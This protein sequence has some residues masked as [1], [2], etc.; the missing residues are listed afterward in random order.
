MYNSSSSLTINVGSESNFNDKIN[1]MTLPLNNKLSSDE[2]CYTNEISIIK[3][4]V[5]DKKENMSEISKSNIENNNEDNNNNNNNNNNKNNNN[6]NENNNNNNENNNENDISEKDNKLNLKDNEKD[7]QLNNHKQR[8]ANNTN[9]IQNNEIKPIKVENN[10]ENIEIEKVNKEKVTIKQENKINE[11]IIDNNTSDFNDDTNRI[12]TILYNN[13]EKNDNYND[14]LFKLIREKEHLEYRFK[15]EISQFQNQLE[16]ANNA[17]KNFQDI[18]TNLDEELGNEKRKY[19]NDITAIHVELKNYQLEIEYLKEKLD[20]EEKENNFLIDEKNVLI[21]N[22][23]DEKD[24]FNDLKLTIEMIKSERDLLADELSKIIPQFEKLKEVEENFHQKQKE[25]EN[26]KMESEE[27]LNNGLS[28]SIEYMNLLKDFKKQLEIKANLINEA[29]PTGKIEVITESI[30]ELDENYAIQLRDMTDK[31]NI[32]VDECNMLKQELDTKDQTIT[33]K[34]KSI[35]EEVEKNKQYENTIDFLNNKILY[36]S[37][38]LETDDK[39]DKSLSFNKA[40][41]CAAKYIEYLENA[42][43]ENRKFSNDII[44]NYGFFDKVKH[45]ENLK[46][47]NISS[48][49]E[50]HEISNSKTDES[51]VSQLQK[52]ISDKDLEIESLNQKLNALLR[53]KE[54]FANTDYSTTNN[55]NIITDTNET[56]S[57]QI[58]GSSNND[59]SNNEELE[60]LRRQNQKLKEA[61]DAK[62]NLIMEFS[63]IEK[64]NTDES[65]AMYESSQNTQEGSSNNSKSKIDHSSKNSNISNKKSETS[66]S[67]VIINNGSDK[68]FSLDK[69]DFYKIKEIII[70]ILNDNKEREDQIKNLNEKMEIFI[71][72][73]NENPYSIEDISKF[74][75]EYISAVNNIYE[76]TKIHNFQFESFISSS[77][78]LVDK[79]TEFSKAASIKSLTNES[80]TS[81]NKKSI[82]VDAKIQTALD[83]ILRID[84]FTQTNND[85]I[86]KIDSYTQIDNDND[87]INNDNILKS[88]KSDEKVNN[89]IEEYHSNGTRNSNEAYYLKNKFY[90]LLNTI[91]NILEG[92]NKKSKIIRNACQK[93]MDKNNNSLSL[94]KKDSDKL[95]TE[96]N[97]LLKIQN[98]IKDYLKKHKK[99]LGKLIYPSDNDSDLFSNTT[100]DNL[101]SMDISSLNFDDSVNKEL[102]K[103]S[104]ISDNIKLLLRLDDIV[105]SLNLSNEIKG[106]LEE[107]T[108]GL[109]KLWKFEINKY[110][111]Y[112]TFYYYNNYLIIFINNKIYIIFF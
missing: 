74:L 24:K 6:N 91:Y 49:N 28:Q 16:I 62:T 5:D 69:E 39:L 52:I 2:V 101:D 26:S 43:I 18:C 37:N 94:S 27:H 29:N 23:T 22:L 88:V 8:D 25:F 58:M 105:K 55:S 64:N 93:K 14:K 20:K 3:N 107:R 10:T 44:L 66:S 13:K 59:N 67:V 84:S 19:A 76:V 36:Y 41:S 95:I 31:I 92:E 83:N 56:N 17:I 53:Q 65:F 77:V 9:E 104:N 63:D 47:A 89:P 34:D 100:S 112:Y 7:K 32:L 103:E 85:K 111:Y 46:S 97:K 21:N 45:P 87:N 108:E 35:Q 33:T 54:I 99:D 96:L 40:N 30:K 38:I 61:L 90:K 42:F 98:K 51:D 81:I 82:L 60:E 75:K 70:D 86:L 79:S 109:L 68:E 106:K 72:D 15:L 110:K 48:D 78:E 102:N 50:L 12:D 4:S 1:K 71:K 57:N 73:I 11:D 80:D